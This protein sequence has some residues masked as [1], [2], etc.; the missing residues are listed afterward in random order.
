MAISPWNE[1]KCY[2]PCP[3]L[4]LRRACSH[5]E[6]THSSFFGLVHVPACADSAVFC[7]HNVTIDDVNASAQMRQGGCTEGNAD[8]ATPQLLYRPHTRLCRW[9][10]SEAHMCRASILNTVAI[11]VSHSSKYFSR[12]TSPPSTSSRASPYLSCVRRS[13]CACGC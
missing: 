13:Y 6:A 8:D 3:I 12:P 2:P 9:Q 7:C 1:C 10:L 11:P 4:T 5:R